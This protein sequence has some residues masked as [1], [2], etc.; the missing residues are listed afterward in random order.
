[1]SSPSDWP[2][3]KRRKVRKGTQSCWECKR[4]KVRCIFASAEHA[5]CNNCRRRGTSCI[6][7]DL[8]DTRT[9]PSPSSNESKVDARLG[10]VED[11][12]QQL[13]NNAST[14]NSAAARSDLVASYTEDNGHQEILLAPITLAAEVQPQPLSIPRPRPTDSSSGKYDELCRDLVVAWPSKDDLDLLCSLP[15]GLS[16]PLYWGVSTPYTDFI[17]KDPPPPPRE[18]LQL[19]PPGSHPVLIARKLLVL[20]TFIQGVLPSTIKSLGSLGASY[21]DI[22]ARAVDRAVRLVTTNDELI[23]SAEGIECVM[24][25]AMY[26]NY[27]GNLDKAW[28][29]IRR[30]IAAAQ[31]MRLQRGAKSPALRFIE[32]A[33]RATFDPEHICFRL[34]QMERYLAVMLGLPQG[35]LDERFANSK[36]LE[37]CRPLVRLERIHCMI[38]GRILARTNADINDLSKTR[39]VDQLL[40]NA[41]AEMP[42]QWWLNPS[43]ANE[44]E[45]LSDTIRIMTQF[46]HYHLLARLHL[47][48]MLRL[49]SDHKYDH[50]KITAVN[51][52]RDILSRYI[53]FRS[54]NPA[55]F[56]CRGC[57]ILAFVAA[58]IMCIGYISSRSEQPSS[59]FY[60]LSHSR[61]T[62]RGMMECT[63]EIIQSMAQDNISDPI[64]PKLTRIIRHLL[65]VEANAANGTIYSAS[66]SNGGE[67]EIDGNLS[68]EGKALHIHIP[69]FGTINF[70][71]GSV[72]KSS[73]PA[74]D[75]I[76]LLKPIDTPDFP[77]FSSAGDDWDLQG[78]D[79]ALFDN[80]FR[81]F[82]FPDMDADTGAL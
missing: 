6:S 55:H 21:R 46:T 3:N 70:E 18:M 31:L 28:M 80:L 53:N 12:I 75:K 59:V 43:F 40:Q 58:T 82:E 63:S 57:D 42:P 69:Y 44:E 8:P 22:A 2:A 61:L 34:V 67:G 79:I 77:M 81:G 39:E 49:S 60:F 68:H 1:M 48:Y 72:S 13:V 38:A 5:I 52:S 19:P 33:T 27:A 15:T 17:L 74:V 24:M 56:Y 14:Q 23:C 62:D 76:P 32:P 71:R 50:S 54:S 30:A 41:A 26:Y 65:D 78:I 20:G 36:V 10:R 73:Q 64:A 9:L 37:K 11:L 25:E 47:P 66:S 45:I 7:Q 35:P 51:A 16:T 4:R 29:A